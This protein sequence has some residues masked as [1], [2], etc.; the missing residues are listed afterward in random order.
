MNMTKY[1]SIRAWADKNGLENRPMGTFVDSVPTQNGIVISTDFYQGL[2]PD[3]NTRRAVERVKKAAERRGLRYNVHTM[4]VA[5]YV[6]C[7]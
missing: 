7:D 3:E 5:V 2:Y 4:L 6:Y 1:N